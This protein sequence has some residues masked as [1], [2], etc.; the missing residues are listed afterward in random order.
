MSLNGQGGMTAPE[1]L[2]TEWRKDTSHVDAALSH[3]PF[4]E[5]TSLSLPHFPHHI[6]IMIIMTITTIIDIIVIFIN[7]MID[8][9]NLSHNYRSLYISTSTILPND[10]QNKT[11]DTAVWAYH[12]L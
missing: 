9:T 3:L 6:I 2:S 5:A 12:L 4:P 8:D 11:S 10:T 1:Y 7:N